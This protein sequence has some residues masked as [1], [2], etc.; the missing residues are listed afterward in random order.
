MIFKELSTFLSIEPLVYRS[1]EDQDAKNGPVLMVL[2]N[3]AILGL[4]SV[5]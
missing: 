3:V 2:E 1:V 5:L 4:L